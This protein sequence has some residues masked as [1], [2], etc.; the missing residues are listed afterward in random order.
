MPKNVD[1]HRGQWTIPC[2]IYRL[3]KWSSCDYR[4]KFM[5]APWARKC[6]DNGPFIVRRVPKRQ[7]G[8]AVSMLGRTLFCTTRNLI[9]TD[10]VLLAGSITR[11]VVP[12]PTLLSTRIRPLCP[13]MIFSAIDSPRPTAPRS[14]ERVVSPR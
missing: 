8:S 13:S 2:R 7:K 10:Q 12:S 9:E 3:Q 1:A 4:E 14:V 6:M 5:V 11:N